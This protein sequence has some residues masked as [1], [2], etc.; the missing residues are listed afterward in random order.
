MLLGEE[1]SLLNICGF[2]VCAGGILV[3]HVVVRPPTAPHLRPVGSPW[4]PMG[5]H[6]SPVG[7]PLGPMGPTGPV[8]CVS[9]GARDP[10]G[11]LFPPKNVTSAKKM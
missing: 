1:V 8:A 3:Y 2:G 6:G 10:P 11:L 5:A 4:E 7:A 9:R